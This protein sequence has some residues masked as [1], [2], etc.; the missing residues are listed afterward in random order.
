MVFEQHD[1]ESR[2]S[3]SHSQLRPMLARVGLELSE[4]EASALGRSLAAS[5]T[6]P[7]PSAGTACQSPQTSTTG[8]RQSPPLSPNLTPSGKRDS[9]PVD[10]APPGC[11]AG[12]MPPRRLRCSKERSKEREQPEVDDATN[13]LGDGETL[14]GADESVGSDDTL[15]GADETLLGADGTLRARGLEGETLEPSD[16]HALPGVE[17]MGAGAGSG[18]AVGVGTDAGTGA[19]TRL[20]IMSGGGDGAGTDGGSEQHESLPKMASEQHED[21]QPLH[22]T[23]CTRGVRPLQRVKEL[24]AVVPQEDLAHR[25]EVALEALPARLERQGAHKDLGAELGGPGR[26]EGAELAATVQ[27]EEAPRIHLSALLD[28]FATY[29]LRRDFES[30]VMRTSTARGA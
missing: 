7:A 3:I 1:P 28:W 13:L 4:H 25:A 18:A 24:R 15:L 2:G 9:A 5:S 20:Q 22:E 27:A 14:L 6:S 30:Y 29:D 10:P 19:S 8:A 12:G 17:S 21:P 11:C 26:T 16:P 23:S